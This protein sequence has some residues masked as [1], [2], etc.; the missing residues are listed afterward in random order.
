MQHTRLR[1][2]RACRC[3]RHGDHEANADREPQRDHDRLLAASLKLAAQIE[4]EHLN[5]GVGFPIEADLVA[6]V[7]WFPVN[8]LKNWRTFDVAQ[9]TRRAGSWAMAA[10]VRRIRLGGRA[11]TARSRGLR[12]RPSPQ[13][14]FALP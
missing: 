6:T 12:A 2:L 8:A 7:G 5:S 4:K 3:I 13:T 1:G 14:G 10:G 11:E 9:P